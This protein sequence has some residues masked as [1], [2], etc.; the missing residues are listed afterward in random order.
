MDNVLI[1]KKAV[2]YG[3]LICEKYSDFLYDK[4][5]LNFV[6]G[7]FEFIGEVIG[8]EDPYNLLNFYDNIPRILNNLYCFYLYDHV[9]AKVIS[10][11]ENSEC[12]EIVLDNCRIRMYRGSNEKI[13]S[14]KGDLSEAN[15]IVK[16][17]IISKFGDAISITLTNSWRADCANSLSILFIFEIKISRILFSLSK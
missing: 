1:L 9:D 8:E 6:K 5:P 4:D 16:D 7:S 3:K 10:K 14:Y 15:A 11:N 12:K 2:K 17:S 13:F